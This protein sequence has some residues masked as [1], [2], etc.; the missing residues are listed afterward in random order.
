MPDKEPNAQDA[1]RLAID[2]L[3]DLDRVKRA[4]EQLSADHLSP[5]KPAQK[6]EMPGSDHLRQHRMGVPSRLDTDAELRAFILRHIRQM[7]FPKLAE[8]VAQSFPPERRV[9][10]SAIHRWWQREGKFIGQNRQS[11]PNPR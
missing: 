7:T 11:P 9:S 2:A 6:A 8:A 4:V 3:A 5:V 1:K 10:Q